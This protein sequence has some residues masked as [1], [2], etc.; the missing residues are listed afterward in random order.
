MLW[1]LS[2]LILSL[3]LQYRILFYLMVFLWLLQ[4][5]LC[6]HLISIQVP[7]TVSCRMI[8][9]IVR[10]TH[11]DTTLTQKLDNVIY[12]CTAAAEGTEIISGVRKIVKGHASLLRITFLTG[13]SSKGFFSIVLIICWH[14]VAESTKII[15][16]ELY[17]SISV[18][19]PLLIFPSFCEWQTYE[20]SLKW[21]F[22]LNKN[23]SVLMLFISLPNASHVTSDRSEQYYRSYWKTNIQNIF[24]VSYFFVKN[25]PKSTSSHRR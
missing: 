16:I 23:L 25:N 9:V 6:N 1:I 15:M 5:T 20:N 17:Q 3:L 19:P 21:F 10:V 13:F 11:W 24:Y 18:C 7:R 8:E 12:F 2:F 4:L 22:K 14:I